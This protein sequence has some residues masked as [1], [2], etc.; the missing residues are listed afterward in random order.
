VIIRGLPG[1]MAAIVVAGL[2]ANRVY[3]PLGGEEHAGLIVL[4]ALLAGGAA[5]VLV[6][7]GVERVLRWR[8]KQ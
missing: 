5:F 1:A 4:A 7:V 6:T 8:S 2:V 3:K